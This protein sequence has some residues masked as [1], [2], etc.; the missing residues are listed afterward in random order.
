MDQPDHD[1]PHHHDTQASTQPEVKGVPHGVVRG[2]VAI[3]I[4]LLHA[5]MAEPWTRSLARFTFHAPSL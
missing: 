4:R 5:R 2:H 1:C 3:A